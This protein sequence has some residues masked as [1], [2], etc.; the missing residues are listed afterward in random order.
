MIKLTRE[1]S[2][3][4]INPEYIVRVAIHPEETI[5]GKVIPATMVI[6]T[7]DGSTMVYDPPNNDWLAELL[8]PD[9]KDVFRKCVLGEG[10]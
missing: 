10:N 6:T 4:F 2:T 9:W 5:D 3:H 8:S 1:N 7:L